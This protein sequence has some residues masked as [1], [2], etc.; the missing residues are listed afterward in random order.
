MA[1][2]VETPGLFCIDM[3]HLLGKC[4][5][6]PVNWAVCESI[7]TVLLLQSGWCRETKTGTSIG[8]VCAIRSENPLA[9]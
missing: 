7:R 2:V 9:G 1:G 5:Q 6:L 4:I 8:M 3:S